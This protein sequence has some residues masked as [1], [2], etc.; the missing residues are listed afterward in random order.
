MM[1]DARFGAENRASLM[2]INSEGGIFSY[3]T[4]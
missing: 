2:T 3:F 4:V 1:V